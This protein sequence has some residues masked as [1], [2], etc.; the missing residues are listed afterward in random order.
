MRNLSV[1]IDSNYQFPTWCRRPS[2]FVNALSLAAS[3]VENTTVPSGATKVL[4]SCTGNFYA[5]LGTNAAAI[6]TDTSDGSAS[7]LNPTAWT[8]DA[9]AVISVIAPVACTLTL[10]YY[11]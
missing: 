2:D 4:F 7:E 5:K 1:A 11:K 3:T 9:G 8:V 6:P 10:S